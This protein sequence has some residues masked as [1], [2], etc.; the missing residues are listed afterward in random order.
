[1]GPR[2]PGVETGLTESGVEALKAGIS[3]ITAIAVLLVAFLAAGSTARA[4]EGA[5]PPEL[6]N[7]FTLIQHLLPEDSE[8]R[9]FLHAHFHNGWENVFFSFLIVGITWVVLAKGM[10]KRLREPGRFQGAIEAVGEGLFNFFKEVMGERNARDFIP[11]VGALFLFIF[12]NNIAGIVP[13]GKASTST[14]KTTF[15]LSIPVFIIV[16]IV[17]VV[18]CGVWGRL[19]HLMGSPKDVVGWCLSP[20]MFVLEVVGELVKPVSLGLRLYGNILG[21]DI[22]IGAFAL[23]GVMLMGAI[24]LA[25]V[26]VGIPLQFP[27]L[28]LA[29]LTSTIQALVFSLLASIYILLS[30]PHEEH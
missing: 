10:K 18:R 14:W 4:A 5:A 6:P 28:F 8:L 22:L 29:L 2:P 30:L 16:Q 15:A 21:E 7:L 17:G 9:Y 27:F 26:P 11:L 13:L 23:M 3:R 20:L 24:G 1:L 12:F 19:H 25:S